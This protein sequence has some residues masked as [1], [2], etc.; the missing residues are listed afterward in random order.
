MV[1]T[2]AEE[3]QRSIYELGIEGRLVQMQLDELGR[4]KDCAK[5]QDSR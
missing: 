1:M 5:V 3:V 4:C 2:M